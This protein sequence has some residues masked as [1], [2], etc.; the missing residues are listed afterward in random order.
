M[1]PNLFWPIYSSENVCDLNFYELIFYELHVSCPCVVAPSGAALQFCC[2][3]LLQC[4][5]KFIHLYILIP[6]SIVWRWKWGN[7]VRIISF[8]QLMRNVI[9]WC[10]LICGINIVSIWCVCVCACV[11]SLHAY[12]KGQCLILKVDNGMSLSLWI[13]PITVLPVPY[14]PLTLRTRLCPIF[15]EW[16]YPH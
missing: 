13:V 6:C 15:W 14:T 9:K 7:K 10:H 4:Q 11:M 1:A 12:Q 5:L 2:M 16:S 8:D 3:F